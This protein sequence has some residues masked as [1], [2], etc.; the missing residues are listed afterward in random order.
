MAQHHPV[1]RS[2]GKRQMVWGRGLCSIS[3]PTEHCRHG[4]WQGRGKAGEE[5]AKRE[6][7]LVAGKG[8]LSKP[9][10]FRPRVL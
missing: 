2:E 5:L 10:M 3:S 6:V 9:A 4:D 1:P 8:E 7:I